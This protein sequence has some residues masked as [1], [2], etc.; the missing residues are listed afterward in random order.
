MYFSS[1]CILVT[2]MSG[3]WISDAKN[4]NAKNLIVESLNY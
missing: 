4:D 1:I 2:L 3:N